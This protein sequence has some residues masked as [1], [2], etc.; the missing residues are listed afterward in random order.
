MLLDTLD[1]GC[2]YSLGTRWAAVFQEAVALARQG[3]ALP[4]GVHTL[5][6]GPGHGGA[7]ASVSVYESAL[8]GRYES[9]HVMADI[10]I[11]LDGEEACQVLPIPAD[12]PSPLTPEAPYDTGRDIVFY[13]EKPEAAA[14]ICLRPGLFALF[15]PQ[16]AHMPGLALSS[17][18]R[19]K[20]MVVKVPAAALLPRP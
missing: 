9:H 16:D 4:E 13:R 14:R 15:A 18:C 5:A 7:T 11:V 12:H 3:A 20:K 8:T 6:G 10:Q 1:H 2:L 17:P 19:V